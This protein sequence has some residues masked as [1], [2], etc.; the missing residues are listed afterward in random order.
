[1]REKVTFINLYKEQ[2]KLSNMCEVLEISPK[3]YYKYRNKEDT[4][5]YDYLIIKEIFN[6]SSVSFSGYNNLH[7][8]LDKPKIKKK[9]LHFTQAVTYTFYYFFLVVYQMGFTSLSTIFISIPFYFP[10]RFALSELGY[11]RSNTRSIVA[12]A[13]LISCK[14]SFNNVTS[15]DP[16]FSSNRAIFLVPGIGTIHSF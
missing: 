1:M 6:D 7:T 2:Y 13:L 5:Y 4:D 10:I 16:I 14:S 9:Q 8:F 11:Q 3:T 15:T 12:K